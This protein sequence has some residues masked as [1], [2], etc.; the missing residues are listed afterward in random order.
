MAAQARRLIS[1][2]ITLSY[3]PFRCTALPSQTCFASCH[4][5]RSLS[6]ESASRSTT[7][8]EE[9]DIVRRY[10]HLLPARSRYSMD[11]PSPLLA[12][13]SLHLGI[14]TSA[15]RIFVAFMSTKAEAAQKA[16]ET[17]ISPKLAPSDDFVAPDAPAVPDGLGEMVLAAPSSNLHEL[18][19]GSWWPTGILQ[20][21]MD[22]MHSTTGMPWW[23]C[24]VVATVMVRALLFPLVVKAQRNAAYLQ[25][26]MP[27]MQ[28]IQLKMSDA[29][30]RGDVYGSAQ[31]AGELQA[32]MK[33]TGF[34]PLKSM[35]P[36][37]LQAPVFM[38]FFFALRGM[39]NAPVAS[40]E[41]EGALWFTDLTVA[42]PYFALPI[43]TAATLYLVIEFG[44][45]GTGQSVQM[46]QM[47]L[48]KYFMR[49]IP[50]VSLI[51]TS[52]FPT[53][54]LCYWFTSNL[55]SLGQVGL[56]KIPVI[57]KAL[58]IPPKVVHN[59]DHLPMKKKGFREAM[60]DSMQNSRIQR[61]LADR[62]RVDA[63]NF[64]QSGMGPVVKTFKY[65]PTKA[66]PTTQAA[67]QARKAS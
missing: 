41:Q 46:Q 48:M 17:V 20:Q 6:S 35:I 15:S 34:N 31:A 9:A 24:I 66:R 52:Y 22:Y 65:D 10:A 50:F 32:F 44:V 11:R 55:I 64:R 1:S 19:L 67:I 18:G 38:S 3:S 43:M 37:L 26:N 33:R 4:A 14:P 7:G 12:R 40:M 28:Q 8:T 42:D 16:A 25:Q 27:E 56:L 5:S 36:G 54:M 30:S 13:S 59:P 57:R 51:F 2:R 21:G 62:E 53:A 39:A 49:T 47:H 23:A 45:E 58:K 60:R 61:E 29:R 63:V